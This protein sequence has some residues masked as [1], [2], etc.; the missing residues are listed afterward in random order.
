MIDLKSTLR[1]NRVA[2]EK[3]ATNVFGSAVE[4]FARRSLGVGP[5]QAGRGPTIQRRDTTQWYATSY[6]A[7]LAGKTE[8]RPKLKFLFKIEFIFKSE[9]LDELLNAGLMNPS[10]VRALR[11]NGFTFMV[12][13]VDRPKVDFEYEDEVNLY[14]FRTKALKR[15]RHRELT[16]TFMDDTGNRVFDFF[17]AL[18]FIY[19]PITRRATKRLD[20]LQYIKPD[21]FT[22]GMNFDPNPAGIELTE[23]SHRGVINTSAGQ[24]I[25]CIRIRQMFINVPS[26]QKTNSNSWYGPQQVLF[27]FMNPR[28]VSFD[29]D[30]LTHESSEPNLLTMQ[31]DYDWME[32]V[33]VNELAGKDGPRMPMNP[34]TGAPADVLDNN[35]PSPTLGFDPGRTSAGGGREA[36]PLAKLLGGTA[37][38]I[39]RDITGQAVNRA[40]QQI[41][42]RGRIGQMVG[43]AIGGPITEAISGLASGGINKA[44]GAIGGLIADTGSKIAGGLFSTIGNSAARAR[45]PLVS[46]STQAG[47]GVGARGIRSAASVSTG[48]VAEWPPGGP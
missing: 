16:V 38:R 32:M 41:A 44:S 33:P 47:G 48:A 15:I 29:L 46:D 9:I 22:D 36:N 6:A 12:K 25:E 2:L 24:A 8:Y 21:K 14:N 37:N 40:V 5:P 1:K 39:V 42:G 18:M 4:D 10:A 30:D 45:G 17:R 23:N 27:D 20:P 7:A 34:A 31:F 43:S 3:Q 26:T 13:S 35:E 19:S 28:L 11:E